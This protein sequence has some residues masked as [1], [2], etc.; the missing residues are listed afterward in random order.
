MWS[1]VLDSSPPETNKELNQCRKAPIRR[2]ANHRITPALQGIIHIFTV[3]DQ[4]ECYMHNMQLLNL[5]LLHG[6]WAWPG[7]GA[8][9]QSL[10]F[11]FLRFLSR[12]LDVYHCKILSCVQG[13]TYGLVCCANIR[14]RVEILARLRKRRI[15]QLKSR[16]HL[17]CVEG[18]GSPHDAH[19]V[20][21]GHITCKGGFCISSYTQ[22]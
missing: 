1:M 8:D 6:A 14:C 21:S 5:K 16:R 12:L 2:S 9:Y 13:C 17:A 3:Y 20:P 10:Q 7:G 15:S 22:I 11:R 4:Q 18:L 19:I